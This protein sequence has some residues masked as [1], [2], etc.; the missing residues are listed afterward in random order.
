MAVFRV[1]KTRAYTV[2]SNHHLHNKKLSFKAKGLLSFMLSLPEDWNYTERGLSRFA[3]DGRDSI[4]AALLE[5]EAEGYLIRWQSRNEDGTLA[6]MEYTIYEQP[7]PENAPK[8]SLE[9]TDILPWPE[10]PLPVKPSA[11][12]PTIQKT[13]R[14]SIKKQNTDSKY[15][16]S[17]DAVKKELEKQIGYD[18]L[19]VSHH[20]EIVDD[21]LHTMLELRLLSEK[22]DVV[23]VGQEM[24]PADLVQMKI[25]RFTYFH[26]GYITECM[27]NHKEKIRNI[28]GY[29][30]K[31]ILNAPDTMDAFYE[32]E[33]RHDLYHKR[34]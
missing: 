7:P 13:N 23:R 14:Q 27:K 34:E 15:N 26:I 16:L 12:N 4:R 10:N 19:L 20:K 32:A 30:Q 18:D 8:Q 2:M 22:M 31:S 29:L 17:A 9:N 6:E 24:Y 28:K 21:I 3:K 1:D 25:S 33:A 11:E 5:L